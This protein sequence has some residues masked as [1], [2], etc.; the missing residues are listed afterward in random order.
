LC[1]CPANDC[2]LTLNFFEMSRRKLPLDGLQG[3][4]QNYKA[5]MLSG[6][7]VF[8][9]ALPLSLGI[10]AASEFP[11]LYGLITAMIGGIVVS[12]FAG[13]PLTIKG[14]AAG[15]IVIVAGAVAEFGNGN[16]E[17]GWQTHFRRYR[18]SRCFANR[19]WLVQV[20]FSERFLSCICRARNACGNRYNYHKQT[21]PRIVGR[22]PN[23]TGRQVYG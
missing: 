18:R 2:F 17:L 10:A 5:D 6:F 23:D 4:R 1:A 9:L 22:K 13:S 16:Q 12:F 19:F 8:L 3:F 21:S 11:P 20:G 14:P 7:L 15:L